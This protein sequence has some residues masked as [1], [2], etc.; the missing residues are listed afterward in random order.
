M[1]SVPRAMKPITRV[2][3]PNP[4]GPSSLRKTMGKITPPTAKLRSAQSNAAQN[5]AGYDIL[6]YTAS[7]SSQTCSSSSF[8]TEVGSNYGYTRHEQTARTQT[9][10]HTES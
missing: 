8:G 1:A 5:T 7:C 2:A 10:T 3:Q 4:S 9:N 6:T